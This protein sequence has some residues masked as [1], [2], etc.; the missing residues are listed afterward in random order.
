MR[1]PEKENAPPTENDAGHGRDCG[2][3]EVYAPPDDAAGPR[4]NP[5]A[6]IDRDELVSFLKLRENQGPLCP[7]RIPYPKGSNTCQAFTDV[8]EAANWAA[9]YAAEHSLYIVNNSPKEGWTPRKASWQR[10]GGDPPNE[11]NIVHRRRF[12]LDF[13]PLPDVPLE[14]AKREALDLLDEFCAEARRRLDAMTADDRPPGRPAVTT[15]VD[16]GRGI[17][18][19]FDI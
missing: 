1:A 5:D 15:I 16:S 11:G 12:Q 14:D 17:D 6:S 9:R 2:T 18:A 19:H 8:D 7:C 10:D 4:P 3:E 13:D